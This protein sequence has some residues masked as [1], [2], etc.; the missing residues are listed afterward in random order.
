MLH[1][2]GCFVPVLNNA[3]TLVFKTA[4]LLEN[5]IVEYFDFQLKN[6]LS[7]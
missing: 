3:L 2:S 7:L 6:S 5:F 4:H 1:F